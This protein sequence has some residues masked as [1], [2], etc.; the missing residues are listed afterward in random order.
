MKFT[1]TNEQ[2]N[3]IVEYLLECYNSL[4]ETP[5][6]EDEYILLPELEFR[7]D[8]KGNWVSIW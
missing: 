4:Y 3:K 7:R 5:I 1:L 6:I 2:M 8:E